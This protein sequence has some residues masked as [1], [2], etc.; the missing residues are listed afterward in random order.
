MVY[1]VHS[2]S[3]VS[4][5]VCIMLVF[6][7]ANELCLDFGAYYMD[8]IAEHIYMHTEVCALRCF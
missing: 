4:F 1:A 8:Y 7:T 3:T 5:N 2:G 6:T